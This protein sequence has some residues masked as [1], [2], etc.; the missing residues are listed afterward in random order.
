[1]SLGWTISIVSLVNEGA[2]HL[3]LICPV[4][5]KVIQGVHLIRCYHRIT[6][7]DVKQGGEMGMI[8]HPGA[9]ARMLAWTKEH[10]HLSIPEQCRGIKEEL[11]YTYEESEYIYKWFATHSGVS[12]LKMRK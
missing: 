12:G 3:I 8:N 1:M 5:L 10:R 9:V 6:L 7:D 2:V 11:G 4:H